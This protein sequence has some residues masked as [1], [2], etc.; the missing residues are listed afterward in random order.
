MQRSL[1]W[2]G[3]FIGSTIGSYI[4]TLWGAGFFSMSSVLLGAVGAIVGIWIAF[5]IT[6]Y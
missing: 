4:P 3:L 6:Q 1:I 5:K 2:F